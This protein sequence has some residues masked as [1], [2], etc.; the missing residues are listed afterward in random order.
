MDAAVYMKE[1]ASEFDV[2]IVDSSDPV[3]P[4]ETLYTSSFYADMKAALRP[5]GIVC[6]QGECLW[7]HLDL[8]ERVMRDAG[9]LYPLVD[10]AFTTIP[11]YPSGQIGFILACKEGA[12]EG[13]SL[14]GPPRAPPAALQARLRYYNPAVHAA[15]F[16]L[17]QFAEAKLGAVRPKAPAVAAK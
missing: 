16:T 9:A 5:G 15:A 6:T 13:Y 12:V 7:L 17:P 3:G 14:S 1:H 11:S 8:I 2:I 4:A 10:Y